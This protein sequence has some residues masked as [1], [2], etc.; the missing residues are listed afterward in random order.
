[1][2]AFVDSLDLA[3]RCDSTTGSLYLRNVGVFLRDLAIQAT[4]SMSSVC[5]QSVQ[6]W[7]RMR[8]TYAWQAQLQDKLHTT[9]FADSTFYRQTTWSNTI[10]DPGQRITRDIQ[11]LV[12][13]LRV[14]CTSLVNDAL[15]S[16]LACWRIYWEIPDQRYLIPLICMWCA[17]DTHFDELF[18]SL[19]PQ[20]SG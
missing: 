4:V 7:F 18:R 8:I 15:L 11:M 6:T 2:R 14:F 19:E 13:E 12:M 5:V 10:H 3:W 16:L 1:M 20:K 17:T 9:Y